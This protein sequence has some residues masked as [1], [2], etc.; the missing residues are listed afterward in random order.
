VQ[1]EET[2][3]AHVQQSNGRWQQKREAHAAKYEKSKPTSPFQL[4]AVDVD[5]EENEDEEPSLFTGR[6]FGAVDEVEYAYGL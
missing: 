6:Q 2:K 5:V 3:R 4:E 1:A